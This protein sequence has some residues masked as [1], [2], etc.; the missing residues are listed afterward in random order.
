MGLQKKILEKAEKGDNQH[1]ETRL[2]RLS[3]LKGCEILKNSQIK[4]FCTDLHKLA[5]PYMA[6]KR[7][8]LCF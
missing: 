8:A 7:L 1:R 6:I 5:Q 2:K 3:V 4:E